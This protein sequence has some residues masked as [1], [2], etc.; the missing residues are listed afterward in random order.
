[1]A[2]QDRAIHQEVDWFMIAIGF[3]MTQ[4]NYSLT[5]PE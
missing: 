5:T 1:M 3:L 2:R 4:S